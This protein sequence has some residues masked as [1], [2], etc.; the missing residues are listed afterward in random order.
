MRDSPWCFQEAS[1]PAIA[2]LFNYL[3]IL[4]SL[5]LILSTGVASS[6]GLVAVSGKKLLKSQRPSVF[7]IWRHKMLTFENFCIMG[8]CHSPHLR[9]PLKKQRLYADFSE[10]LPNGGVPLSTSAQ[11]L[12]LEPSCRQIHELNRRFPPP[13]P[14]SPRPPHAPATQL[15]WRDWSTGMIIATWCSLSCLAQNSEKSVP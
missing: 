3:L 9:S 10:F 14:Y 12:S 11:C 1:P 13:P 5:Y 2:C 15:E 6:N 8:A 4:F 7:T